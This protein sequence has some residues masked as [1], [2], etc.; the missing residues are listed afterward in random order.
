MNSSPHD[1]R[2]TPA[3]DTPVAESESGAMAA[4]RAAV[5]AG[6]EDKAS[7]REIITRLD[8]RAFGMG[9]LFFMAPVCL[10]MPPGVHTIAGFLLLLFAVQLTLG[11]HRLWLPGWIQRRQLS[12]ERVL[13]GLSRIARFTR[14]IERLA[15]PRWLFMTGSLGSRAIGIVLII[16][17]VILILPIPILGNS[18]P[19]LAACILAISLAERDGVFVFLGIGASILAVIITSA[20]AITAFRALAGFF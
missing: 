14:P 11:R 2:T 6:D 10:P 3:A 20:L 15:K 18:P 19:A 5:S 9:V 1:I 13:R 12:K 16:L 4:L 8:Q 17:A 7:I